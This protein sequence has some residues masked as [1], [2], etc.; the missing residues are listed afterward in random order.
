M[1]KFLIPLLNELRNN[2]RLRLGVWLIIGLLL[3]YSIVLLDDYR[4]KT[5]QEY[6]SVVA[7]LAQLKTIANQSQWLER[8][9]EIKQVRE[10]VQGQLWQAN[11]KGLAQATFQQWLRT[12][13]KQLEIETKRLQVDPALNVAKYD[14][15][16]QV[17]AKIRGNFTKKSLTDFLLKIATNPS[18]VVTEMLDVHEYK[19]QLRFVVIV[20]AY[21]QKVVNSPVDSNI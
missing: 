3:G 17:T 10:Q 19:E 14:N 5:Q 7:R 12:M 2:T 15:I 1:P 18:V 13:T 8:T 20:K 4:L 16:W 9:A 6:T 21:F 11:T